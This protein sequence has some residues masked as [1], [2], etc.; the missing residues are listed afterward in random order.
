MVAVAYGVHIIII[1]VYAAG[2]KILIKLSF[3]G[4]GIISIAY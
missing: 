1:L 4:Y 2:R 3:S